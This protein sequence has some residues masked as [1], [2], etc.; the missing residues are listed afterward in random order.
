MAAVDVIQGHYHDLVGYLGARNCC[1][2]YQCS[3]ILLGQLVREMMAQGI[4]SP[5]PSRPF[6]GFSVAEALRETRDIKTPN[7]KVIRNPSSSHRCDLQSFF[8]DYM[9]YVEDGLEDFDLQD[10]VKTS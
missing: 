6:L 9:E 2:E 5:R 10:F 3:W 8:L 4:F 1:S 7:W